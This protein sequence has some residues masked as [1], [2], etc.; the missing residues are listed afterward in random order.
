MSFLTRSN[1]SLSDSSSIFSRLDDKSKKLPISQKSADVVE[2]LDDFRQ[3]LRRQLTEKTSLNLSKPLDTSSPSKK[4]SLRERLETNIFSKQRNSPPKTELSAQNKTPGSKLGK[5]SEKK[6][7]FAWD[8]ARKIDDRNS[9][10]KT[11]SRDAALLAQLERKNYSSNPLI[12]SGIRNSYSKRDK[13]PIRESSLQIEAKTP[14]YR[15]TPQGLRSSFI[16]EE[17]LNRTPKERKESLIKILDNSNTPKGAREY[18]SKLD[19]DRSLNGI[20]QQLN[21][22]R[23]SRV[24]LQQHSPERREEYA[25][26]PTRSSNTNIRTLSNFVSD[27]FGRNRDDN[28]NGDKYATKKST[29]LLGLGLSNKGSSTIDRLPVSKLHEIQDLINGLSNREFDNLSSEYV[30]ELIKVS[31]IIMKRVKGS[32]YYSGNK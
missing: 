2:S 3:G 22:L 8:L 28:T 21:Q 26:T 14:D 32:T 1:A 6:L 29:G 27:S 15:K 24:A 17:S 20:T 25:S 11:P 10:R 16:G 4:Q 18:G 19:S 23:A 5:A 7:D 9:P 30:E 13:S 31:S 12:T